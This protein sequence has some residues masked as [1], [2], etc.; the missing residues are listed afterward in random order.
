MIS[1][2]AARLRAVLDQP[3]ADI[4]SL[5]EAERIA[6]ALIEAQPQTAEQAV[7][8]LEAV[9][10]YCGLEHSEKQADRLMYGAAR[11]AIRF[12]SHEDVKRLHVA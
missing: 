12:L 11:N 5:S 3:T 2:L 7:L 6:L 1:G 8:Q 4:T 10:A 9:V